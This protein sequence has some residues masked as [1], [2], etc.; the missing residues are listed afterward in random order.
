MTI[1]EAWFLGF[2]IGGF[3]VYLLAIKIFGRK[4]GSI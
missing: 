1:L 2:I 3:I 4:S